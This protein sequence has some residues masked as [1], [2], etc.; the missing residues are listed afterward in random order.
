[1]N[2]AKA[3]KLVALE[4][5]SSTN[6]FYDDYLP[7]EFHLR[8]C[9]TMFKKFRE[10]AVKVC[11]LHGINIEALEGGIWCHDTIEDARMNYNGIIKGVTVLMKPNWGIWTPETVIQGAEVARALTNN[12]RGRNRK[13]RMPDWIYEDIRET[14][15]A[16]LGKLID[17]GANVQYSLISAGSMFDTHYKEFPTF[18]QKLSGT[19]EFTLCKPLVD[20]IETLIKDGE[21]QN[22]HKR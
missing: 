2:L 9:N 11:E 22:L 12:V 13:E 17:K 3:F 1:M 18:I 7:Y 15:G 4:A 21:S 6:H 8:M 10:V 14:K 16:T 20:Y 19:E 5:H